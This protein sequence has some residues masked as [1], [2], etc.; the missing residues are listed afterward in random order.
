MR[1]LLWRSTGFIF[2]IFISQ[3][4]VSCF[5]RNVVLDALVKWVRDFRG[6]KI[7]EGLVFQPDLI[8]ATG[9]IAY[10]GKEHE[11]EEATKFL[12][13]LLEAAA[14]ER[15]H[16]FV[17]PGNHDCDR[18]LGLGLARSL[19]KQE[20][21]QYFERKHPKPQITQKQRAFVNWYNKY[22]SD[23]SRSFPEN[24]TC[25]VI[26]NVEV[27][28]HTLAILQLNSALFCQGDDDERKLW[29]G[30]RCLMDAEEQLKQNDKAKLKIAL[31]HHPLHWLHEDDLGHVKPILQSSVDIVLQGHLH[32]ADAENVSGVQGKALYLTAGAK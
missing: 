19:A 5:D 30:R 4:V 24:S 2:R 16:L 9:D 8:F 32:T 10:S 3:K 28:G 22:F 12:D 27:N 23:I 18:A 1:C 14:V 11:Y 21:D 31:V 7:G 15:T 20:F 25:E 17:V 26:Q 29:I 6:K 13:K